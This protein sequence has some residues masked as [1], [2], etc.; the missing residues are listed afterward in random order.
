MLLVPKT[1]SSAQNRFIWFADQLNKLPSSLRGLPSL[2]SLPVLKGIPAE[3]A[4]E[5]NTPSRFLRPKSESA[6]EQQRLAKREL[7]EDESIESFILRRNR[8]GTKLARNLISAVIHGIYA[9]DIRRLSVRSV[10]GFLWETERVHGGLM[11][12]FLLR[13]RFNK[14]YREPTEELVAMKQM[15]SDRL[16]QAEEA[17]GAEVVNDFKNISVY[18]FPEGLQELSDAVARQLEG[19]SNVEIHKGTECLSVRTE[20]GKSVLVRNCLRA[21]TFPSAH[22]TALSGRDNRWQDRM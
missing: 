4:K 14:R 2:L 17:L 21:S 6:D 18:S 3:L 22:F 19:M 16:K 11:R 5:F 8:G 20:D 15:E 12:R 7:L 13:P 1:A 10:L 9:G